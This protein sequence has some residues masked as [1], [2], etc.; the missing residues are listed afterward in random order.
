[1]PREVEDSHFDVDWCVVLS[2]RLG[3]EGLSLKQGEVGDRKG[4]KDVEGISFGFNFV[5][6]LFLRCFICS[7]TSVARLRGTRAG[8]GGGGGAVLI[9]SHLRLSTSRT[10]LQTSTTTQPRHT[11]Q[12]HKAPTCTP[13]VAEFP[14]PPSH[15]FSRSLAQT[16]A[17]CQRRLPPQ[18]RSAFVP[19]PPGT[20]TTTTERTNG[21]N[22]QTNERTN[23]RTNGDK[24]LSNFQQLVLILSFSMYC[25]RS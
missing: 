4:K 9:K 22:E 2:L 6:L 18:E 19:S 7:C 16:R 25:L 1:M 3:R 21:T 17:R 5:R 24:I 8:G 14:Q 12:Q 23:E 20:A 13:A 15:L 10:A 11:T